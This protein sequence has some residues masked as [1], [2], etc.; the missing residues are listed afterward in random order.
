MYRIKNSSTQPIILA[1]LTFRSLS[2]TFI[3][4]ITLH[5]MQVSDRDR[6]V[7]EG[8]KIGCVLMNFKYGGARRYKMRTGNPHP[9]T[10]ASRRPTFWHCDCKFVTVDIWTESHNLRP[11]SWTR[12]DDRDFNVAERYSVRDTA[13]RTELIAISAFFC[14]SVRK[15]FDSR[16]IWF[17]VYEV[18][19]PF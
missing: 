17:A 14:V 9:Q 19:N 3:W 4:W 7:N 18:T 8:R 11:R 15:I 5:L 16:H 2:E 6:D 10:H 12:F 13:R 1:S